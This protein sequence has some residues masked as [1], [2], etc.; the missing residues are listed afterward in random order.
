MAFIFEQPDNML[1]AKAKIINF[2]SNLKPPL[3]IYIIDELNLHFVPSIG[4]RNGLM[5]I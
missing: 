2:L 1:I 3:H 5:Q 4:G